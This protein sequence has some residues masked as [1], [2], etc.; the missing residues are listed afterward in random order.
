MTKTQEEISAGGVV[1]QKTQEQI[2]L[3]LICR[4]SGTVWCLP[5]GKVEKGEA[6]EQTAIRE[7]SEETGLSG[8]INSFLN[9]IQY[10][11]YSKERNAKIEK[12]VH[13]F[14]IKCIGGQLSNADA[15]VE[16]VKWFDLEAALDRVNYPGE[17]QTIEKAAVLLKEGYE[18]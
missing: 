17:R 18:V 5:K 9:K 8:K 15:K 7:V 14:L 3:I 2:K 1:F 4:D 10:S 16:D 13:F 6:L 11:Y 12:T